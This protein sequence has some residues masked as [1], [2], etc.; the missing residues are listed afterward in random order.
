MHL[1][2]HDADVLQPYHV[3]PVGDVRNPKPLVHFENALV[4]F[5]RVVLVWDEQPDFVGNRGF[6]R[7]LRRGTPGNG[8]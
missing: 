6:G 4:V 7:L 2:I 1:G 8:H 5:W 3:H